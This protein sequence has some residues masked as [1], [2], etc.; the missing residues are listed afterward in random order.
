MT[1]RDIR[2][3]ASTGIT[4]AEIALDFYRAW[5][6]ADTDRYGSF[7]GER[8]RWFVPGSSAIAGRHAGPG[9]SEA[10]RSRL[11]EFDAGITDVMVSIAYIG[12]DDTRPDRAPHVSILARPARPADDAHAHVILLFHVLED[13]KIGDIW[14]YP[15]DVNE[16]DAFAR[17]L[18][19]DAAA[20]HG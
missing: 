3:G 18:S 1:L 9:A 10:L 11:G 16:L 14:I 13:G 20:I 5:I 4:A 12:S 7:E 2:V 8:T 19:T 17:A 15:E 6:D